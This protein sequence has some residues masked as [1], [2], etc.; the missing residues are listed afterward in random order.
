MLSHL[1]QHQTHHRG[2]AHAMLSGTS[3]RPPQLDEYIVADDAANRA[4]VLQRLGMTE[5][6]V[7][8]LDN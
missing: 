4:D 2:Q 7:M 8:D 5:A 6:Q 3:I 1:F